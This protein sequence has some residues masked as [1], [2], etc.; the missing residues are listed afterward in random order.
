MVVENSVDELDTLNCETNH[1]TE[2]DRAVE[3]IA[4]DEHPPDAAATVDDDKMEGGRHRKKK[5]F[6]LK[7]QLSNADTKLRDL[8]APVSRRG[9]GASGGTGGGGGGSSGGG[10]GGIVSPHLPDSKPVSPQEEQPAFHFPEPANN[11]ALPPLPPPVSVATLPAESI[12]TVRKETQPLFDTDGAPIRPPRRLKKSLSAATGPKSVSNRDSNWKRTWYSSDEAATTLPP[13]PIQVHDL[14]FDP[15][16]ES[17]YPGFLDN[18]VRKFSKL[19]INPH[20]PPEF[21]LPVVTI[22]YAFTL[23]W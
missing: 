21:L 6:N 18:L 1:E 4:D 10:V 7:K 14:R 3:A 12:D 11:S 23:T 2:V 20:P 16:D 22:P 9:S 17:C 19:V 13:V 8:F 15:A 5:N